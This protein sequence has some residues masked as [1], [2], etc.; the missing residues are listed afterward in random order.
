MG[1]LLCNLNPIFS[2]EQE[3]KRKLKVETKYHKH[4]IR[5]TISNRRGGA[6]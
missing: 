6:A 5:N 1:F 4:H 3:M 2:D